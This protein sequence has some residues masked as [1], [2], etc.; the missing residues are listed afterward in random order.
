MLTVRGDEAQE[1]VL[2][3]AGDKACGWDPA[4]P[5][6]R[7]PNLG[8]R[9]MQDQGLAT[10]GWGEQRGKLVKGTLA[11]QEKACILDAVSHDTPSQCSAPFHGS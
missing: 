9:I 1:T 5:A 6:A 8:A 4:P 11:V 10:V 7:A 3:Q 2:P